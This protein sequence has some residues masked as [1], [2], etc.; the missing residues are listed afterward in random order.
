MKSLVAA[1]AA[2][3]LTPLTLAGHPAADLRDATPCG[4]EA[5]FRQGGL[6][7]DP[8]GRT[9]GTV[10]YTDG[11]HPRLK[12]RLQGVVWK[13]KTFHDDGT[14]TN[15]WLGGLDAVSAGVCVEPSWLD[16]QPCF[17][18]QYAPDAPVF[19]NVRDELRE[20]APDTWLGRSYDAATGR[21][22]NWFV[23]RRK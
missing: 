6:G 14:F 19:A 8:L 17:V 13:G 1:V 3:V 20:I 16:G 22:K 5:L 11:G 15:R 10:L 21:P 23:L 18:M 9:R 7:C 4:L 2:L 12:A